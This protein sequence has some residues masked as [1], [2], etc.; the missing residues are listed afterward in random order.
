MEW[1]G[2]S[3]GFVGVFVLEHGEMSE[4]TARC[5]IGGEGAE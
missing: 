1:T 4:Q 3:I 2:D 5:D